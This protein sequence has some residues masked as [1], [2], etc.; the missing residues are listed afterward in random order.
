MG[1]L[2]RVSRVNLKES[3][4][5][6]CNAVPSPRV[7]LYVQKQTACFWRASPTAAGT[8]ERG[9]QTLAPYVTD[10]GF[11]GARWHRHWSESYGARVICLP[12][13]DILKPWPRRL[14]RFV[15]GVR[16]I[17]ETINEKLHYAFRS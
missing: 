15:A 17:V 14:R 12:K 3:I 6:N 8:G 11:E 7:S 10:K 4:R 9:T 13:R 2:S 1:L 16:Q 5:N